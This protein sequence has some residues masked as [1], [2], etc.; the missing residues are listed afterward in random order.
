[1][2]LI[3][4]VIT[5]VTVAITGAIGCFVVAAEASTLRLGQRSTGLTVTQG[6]VAMRADKARQRFNVDGSGI[7]VGVISDSFNNLGGAQTDIANGDL[8]SDITVLKDLPSE[9]SDEARA[10]MQIIH[11]VAPGAKFA[12]H[13]PTASPNDLSTVTRNYAEAIR[14]LADA[15]AKIIVSDIGDPFDP[16]FQD[17]IIAQ[18]IDSVAFRPGNSGVS[19]FASAGNDARSSYESA[20]RSSGIQDSL[21]GGEFHNFNSDGGV[22]IFQKITIPEGRFANFFFQWDEP[23][24]SL[25]SKG[26]ENDLDFY[27]YDS[28]GTNILAQSTDANIGQDPAE[29]FS[30]PNDG[31]TQE[32]NLAISKKSGNSPGLMK[33]IVGGAGGEFQINEYDTKSG[34]TFG[35]SNAKGAMA[36]GAVSYLE[37]PEFGVNPARKRLFSSTGCVPILFDTSGNRLAKPECREKPGIMAPDGVNNTFFGNDIEEDPD[38]FPNFS[39]SSAAA[40]HAAAV[41]ALMLQL[42]PNLTPTQIYSILKETALDMDD[43]D[44]PGFDRGFDFATGYG[45]INAEAAIARVQATIPEPSLLL[46]ILIVACLTRFTKIKN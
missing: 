3:Y 40:P 15:G 1:M 32:F 35:Y 45:F 28:S 14:K 9:G 19:F 34:T 16:M 18:T 22:D 37:T 46:G 43:P 12:F 5:S 29:F 4:K 21:N 30:F 44:T 2:K 25:G 23:F 42:N 27:L 31:L 8:P 39:G 10:L 33:Y 24:A 36:V 38:D 41:A 7:L 17:G 13:V 6:D 11:D 20:F 26:S